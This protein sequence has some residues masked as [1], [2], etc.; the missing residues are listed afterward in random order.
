MKVLWHPK[1]LHVAENPKYVYLIF[2]LF[3]WLIPDYSVD[4]FEFDVAEL[5]ITVKPESEPTPK[6]RKE[7]LKEVRRKQSRLFDSWF[8]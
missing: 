2:S 6:D 1:V 4:E 7:M 5:N 3:A 8:N